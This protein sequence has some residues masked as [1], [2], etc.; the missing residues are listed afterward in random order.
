MKKQLNEELF[1]GMQAM[2]MN[3]SLGVMGGESAWY[4]IAYG[5][6]EI[7]YAIRHAGGTQSAGQRLMNAAF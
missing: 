7:G 1:A 2:S 4:W 3:E 6:G 5:I